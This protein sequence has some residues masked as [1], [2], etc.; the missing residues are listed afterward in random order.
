M[1]KLVVFMAMFSA[2]SY[3][4]IEINRD[5]PRVPGA[6]EA[7]GSKE[8]IRIA[9]ENRDIVGAAAG[10]A[11]GGGG[12]KGVVGGVI[13]AVIARDPSKPR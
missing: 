9:N 11:I 3:A 13:G 4:G 12:I 8:V 5:D 2:T 10:S 6:N 1:K 7:A